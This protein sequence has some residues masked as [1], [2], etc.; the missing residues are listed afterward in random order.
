MSPNEYV[1]IPWLL[2]DCIDVVEIRFN[3]SIEAIFTVA[4]WS[5]GGTSVRADNYESILGL[6]HEEF[7]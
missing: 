7:P 3:S 1:L 2:K 6:M 5:Q 4:L